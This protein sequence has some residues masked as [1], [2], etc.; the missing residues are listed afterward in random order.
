M[1]LTS[2]TAH[3]SNHPCRYHC[4]NTASK[5]I[6]VH[7]WISVEG[8]CKVQHLPR[9]PALLLTRKIS[10][11][12]YAIHSSFNVLPFVFLI[13]SVT[14]PAPQNSITNW[15]RKQTSHYYN[16]TSQLPLALESITCSSWRLCNVIPAKNKGSQDN[17]WNISLIFISS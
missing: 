7:L 11:Q 4:Q 8:W 12:M 6:P 17:I 10:L 3:H 16:Y 1:A 14:E 2:L 9:Y 15:Q 13:R 5:R